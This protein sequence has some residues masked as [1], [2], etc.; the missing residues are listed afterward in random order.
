VRS[1]LVVPLFVG[2]ELWGAINVEEDREGAFDA[3]DAL[4][5]QTVAAQVGSAMRSAML[6]ERLERAYLGTAEALAA[7]LEAKEQDR[8]RDRRGDSIVGFAEAVGREMR[9]DDAALHDLRL[10][11]V[12]HDIGKIAVPGAIL[13]Q[14]G[15]L[16]DEE[17][18]V[19]ERHPVVG[20]QIL[21]PVEFLESVREIVRHEH[22]RFDGGGYPDGLGGE[23]I[24]LASRIILACDALHAMTSD[25]AYRG[26]MS[27]EQAVGELCR[28]AGTQ[29]DPAV[30]EAVLRVLGREDAEAA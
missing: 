1:E 29:F 20:E 17:R 22:E 2:D 26:A 19:I 28:H 8:D 14:P 4:L 24:P 30:V 5:L 3:D 13:H 16:A 21:S 6:Y 23:D 25:R 15:P 10:A 27:S 7:A 18:A 11:A 12:F 9:L